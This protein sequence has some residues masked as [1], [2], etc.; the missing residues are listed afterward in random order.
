M[1]YIRD[2]DGPLLRRD[3]TRK[4]SAEGNPGALLH[5][6]FQSLRRA[7]AENVPLDEKDRSGVD[8]ERTNDPRQ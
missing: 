7:R 1:V 5:L 4:A 6:F 2:V 3:A 8:N